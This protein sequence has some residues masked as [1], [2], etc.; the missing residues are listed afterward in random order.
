MVGKYKVVRNSESSRASTV[1]YSMKKYLEPNEYLNDYYSDSVSYV[2]KRFDNPTIKNHEHALKAVN[3]DDLN[4]KIQSP[5][6]NIRVILQDDDAV[7]KGL[8]NHD[9]FDHS[10]SKILD[11]EAVQYFSKVST[12]SDDKPQLYLENPTARPNSSNDKQGY[13]PCNGGV[14]GPS[15]YYKPGTAVEVKWQVKN[16]VDSG[17]CIIKLAEKNSESMSSYV[18]LNPT[19]KDVDPYTGFFDCGE[20]HGHIETAEVY[21]PIDSHCAECTL[22]LTYKIEGAGEIYQCSDLSTIHVEGTMD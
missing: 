8:F 4:Y 21:I 20:R 12:L 14:K 16:Q 6:Q 18:I 1:P 11:F 15:T 2:Q 13:F 19:G 9:T 5:H 10:N 3:P 7:K 22:Q 17:Q